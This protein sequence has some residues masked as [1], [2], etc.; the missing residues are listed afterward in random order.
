MPKLDGLV[1]DAVRYRLASKAMRRALAKPRKRTH[2]AG[3]DPTQLR[4]ELDDLAAAAGRGD[5][6]VREYLIVRRPLEDRLKAALAVERTDDDS[7]V[8]E[9]FG[10]AA[11]P[12]AMFDALPFERQRIVLAA[13]I[14]RISVKPSPD[15]AAH[16]GGMGPSRRANDGSF[17]T[18]P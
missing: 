12:A 6:P 5:L 8:L 13:L 3:E 4:A 2:V 11:D 17:G 18:G 7:T 15:G 9:P 1:L 14:D 10:G 16:A